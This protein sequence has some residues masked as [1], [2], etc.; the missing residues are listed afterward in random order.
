ML[1]FLKGVKTS[2]EK[3]HLYIFS[4]WLILFYGIVEANI[5]N[6]IYDKKS[7]LRDEVR[8]LKEKECNSNRGFTLIEL[9]VVIAIILILAG[10][11]LPIVS[12]S[13]EEAKQV[14]AEADL[15]VIR[16]AAY[17]LHSDTNAWPKADCVTGPF[18]GGSCWDGQDLVEDTSGFPNWS[19]PY[20][21]VWQ[22]DPWEY[23][24][25]VYDESLATSSKLFAQSFG[26][27]Q[28]DNGC[29]NDDICVQITSQ[30]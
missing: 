10:S 30:D 5:I 22:L 3:I 4:C 15:D 17:M 1:R 26:P 23:Y 11:L 8:M 19:G 2:D 7:I 21:S 29:S 18:G 13:K 20:I 9:I 27:D 6:H 16:S 28:T 24:Y 12:T 14:K 25:R